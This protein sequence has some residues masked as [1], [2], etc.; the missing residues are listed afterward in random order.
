MAA[1]SVNVCVEAAIENPIQEIRYD[2][3]EI[4]VT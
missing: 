3:Q 4:H 2:G 1:P